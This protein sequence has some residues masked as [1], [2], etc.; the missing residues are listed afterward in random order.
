MVMI[1]CG[2]TPVYSHALSPRT[3]VQFGA[4]TEGG[5][6]TPAQDFGERGRGR[7]RE[8]PYEYLSTLHKLAQCNDKGPA[9]C[10]EPS[11][12]AAISLSLHK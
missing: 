1:I 11:T 2:N 6:S 12:C 7:E 4:A 5:V 3:L 8:R 10:E 9:Q